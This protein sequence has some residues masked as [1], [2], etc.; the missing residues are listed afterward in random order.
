MMS[1]RLICLK[2]FTAN[3][4]KNVLQK[5]QKRYLHKTIAYNGGGSLPVPNHHQ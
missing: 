1:P 5:Q 2:Y 4:P 3:G